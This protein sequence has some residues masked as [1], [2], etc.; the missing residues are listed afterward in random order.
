MMAVESG[1]P[2]PEQGRILSMQTRGIEMESS[3]AGA[4]KEGRRPHLRAAASLM[5]PRWIWPAMILFVTLGI[6]ARLVRYLVD[7][8]IW[9]DEAFLAVNFWDRDYA[10]LLRPLDYGQVAPWLFLVVE[11]AAV[12][13]LGY[14][15]M[16]LRLI[17][18]VCGM[19]SVLV[20][21]HV[22][23]RLLNGQAR[24]LAVAVFAVSFYPIRHGA[25]IKPYASDLLA[26]LVLL[27]LAFEWLR[28]R[29][30]SRW[31][32]VMTGAAPFLVAL[33]YPAVFVAG[34]VSLAL[35]RLVFQTKKPP[36]QLAFIAFNLTLV[37]S[38]IA[39]YFSCAVFQE[40]VIGA[41]YREGCWAESFPPFNR[42]W[43][44]P[45]WLL[46]IHTGNMLAYPVGD[47]HGGSVLTFLFVVA[48]ARALSVRDRKAILAMLLAPFALGLLAAVLGKYP[49]GGTARTMQYV[50]PSICL[51]MGLGMAEL[52][53]L[54]PWDNTRRGAIASA[55][56]ALGLLGC[57]IVARDLVKPYR[58]KEDAAT[59]DFARWFWKEKTRDAGLACVKTDLGLSFNERLWRVGMSAVYLFHQRMYSDRHRRREPLELDPRKY[60]EDR[61][62]RLV[63][64]DYT[65]LG[66]E[67]LGMFQ[68]GLGRSFDL[69]RTESYIVQAG[70]VQEDWLGDAYTVLEFVPRREPSAT[71]AGSAQAQNPRRL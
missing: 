52:A 13:W 21:H 23:G 14:S 60:G 18:A 59:R 6:L 37:A 54:V 68:T 34:G 8:P 48:G 2:V 69:R 19:L 71:A 33:S 20:F 36:V 63:V 25:E 22:S 47:K 3:V 61:P 70:S 28:D 50:A 40:A 45:L 1:V 62:L 24:L 51:L 67:K 11:R 27:A 66:R 32:W 4:D 29:D 53:A 7:Y 57:G 41:Q 46:D 26:A 38:F 64:F 58:V 31:W 5:E 44:L 39:V 55:L 12:I 16:V 30:A 43:M 15:E 65:P 9:H 56:A 49:Y 35:A 10:D 42:P 17:P